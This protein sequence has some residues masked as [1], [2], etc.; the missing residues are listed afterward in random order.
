[1]IRYLLSE[2][3]PIPLAYPSPPGFSP[4]VIVVSVTAGAA[5]FVAGF[6]LIAVRDDKA[7]AFIVGISAGAASLGQFA[8]VAVT[9][10]ATTGLLLLIFAPICAL[11]G[12]GAGVTFALSLQTRTTAV[13]GAIPK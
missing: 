8:T 12:V 7:R 10:A 11:L 13:D 5:L 6:S 9:A 4:G 2:A 1:V 3:W